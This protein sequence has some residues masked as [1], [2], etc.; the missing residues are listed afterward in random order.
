[1]IRS[2]IID[3]VRSRTSNSPYLMSGCRAASMLD[4]RMNSDSAVMVAVLMPHHRSRA[5]VFV[6]RALISVLRVASRHYGLPRPERL[7]RCV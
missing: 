3:A 2:T 5:G 4:L 1:M 7:A 6:R